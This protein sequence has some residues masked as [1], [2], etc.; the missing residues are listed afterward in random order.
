[1]LETAHSI[2]KVWRAQV[3]SDQLFSE[4]NFVLS[5]F[6]T[7]FLQ[8][9]KRTAELLLNPSSAPSITSPAANYALVAQGMVL[10]TD[11]FYDLTCHDLPP[12][13]EDN[14]D[15]FFGA[16]G[17]FHRFISW[18]PAELRGDVD[19]T[20]PSLPSKLK[21][22]ILEIS[23]LWMKLYPEQLQRSNAVATIVQNVWLLIGSDKLPSIADDALVSQALRFISTAIRTGY[24]KDLFSSK[25]TISTLV[26][27]V[28]IPNVSL[29]EHDVEQFE[30]DPLEFIRLDLSLS[31]TGTD[32]ATRRHAAADVL[33]ALVASGYEADTTEIVGKWINTG[34]ETYNSNKGENWK[35]KDSAIFLLTAIATRG[36]TTQVSRVILYSSLDSDELR[37]SMG[38]HRQ[39]H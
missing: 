34:L 27:G 8:L 28:V 1:M 12:A 16:Q 37:N 5:K 23:E 26:Q 22:G 4:I 19:D 18:D 21:T 13:F 29:R 39:T 17:W 11:I 10:L 33:Q 32:L 38:S 9:F 31:A 15:E 7:P 3:R 30:D 35:A 25:E 36:S 24:Y 2:F 14:Y 20:E 6:V